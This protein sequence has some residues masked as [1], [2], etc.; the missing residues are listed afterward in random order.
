M[1]IEP[2]PIFDMELS[3]ICVMEPKQETRQAQCGKL[4]LVQ[5]YTLNQWCSLLE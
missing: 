4:I 1:D 2:N 3:S 5:T